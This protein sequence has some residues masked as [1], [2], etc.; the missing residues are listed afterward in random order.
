MDYFYSGGFSGVTSH[1][2]L[3]PKGAEELQEQCPLGC[4]ALGFTS[5]FLGEGVCIPWTLG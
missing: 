1:D 4:P 2:F 3:R 5:L